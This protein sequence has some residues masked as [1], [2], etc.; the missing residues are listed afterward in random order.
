MR[1]RM[2]WALCRDRSSAES[3][4]HKLEIKLVAKSSG[5]LMDGKRTAIY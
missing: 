5:A 1:R 4:K 3:K 2:A